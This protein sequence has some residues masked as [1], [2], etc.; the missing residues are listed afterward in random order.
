MTS[1]RHLFPNYIW[2]MRGGDMRQMA[3]LALHFLS[4]NVRISRFEVYPF[5]RSFRQ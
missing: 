1:A 5:L 3:Y 4:L 2:E